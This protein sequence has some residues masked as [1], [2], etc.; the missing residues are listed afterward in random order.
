MIEQAKSKG[1]ASEAMMWSSI[2]EVDELLEKM[3]E[4]HKEMYW[5]FMHNQHKGLYKGH[6]D[7]EFAEYELE[8]TYYI[9]KGGEKTNKPYWTVEEIEAATKNY[10]FPSGTTKWDKW[11][12]FNVFMSDTMQSLPDDLQNDPNNQN[13]DYQNNDARQNSAQTK[14]TQLLY[15]CQ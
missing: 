14:I 11:V 4:H 3:R 6:Y 2:E 5:A 10:A 15:F 9:N 8:N 13:A 1:V 12:A 7:E